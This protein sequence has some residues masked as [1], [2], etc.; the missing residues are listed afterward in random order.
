MSPGFGVMPIEGCLAV[1]LKKQR[2]V[3]YGVGIDTFEIKLNVANWIS[4]FH[5]NFQVRNS[6]SSIQSQ[7]ETKIISIIIIIIILI[8]ITTTTTITTTRD[9]S[10][11][12]RIIINTTITNYTD[13]VA[14]LS[15]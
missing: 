1:L 10:S 12:R 14:T 11:I 4:Q 15:Q 2:D 9:C 3:F 13:M 6:I 7:G 5:L 8:N